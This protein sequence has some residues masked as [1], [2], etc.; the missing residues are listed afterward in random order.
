MAATDRHGIDLA[1]DLVGGEV[2][3]RSCRMLG[4]GGVLVYLLAE[5]FED[6]SA[7]HGVDLRQ[8]IIHDDRSALE[9]VV[10]LAAA[11]AV[12]PQVSRILKL[13]E[14]ARAHELIEAGQNSRGRIVLEIA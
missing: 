3:E 7:A 5:P 9:R 8:A 1:F 14:A 11:G 6:C 4:P 2:H 13:A 12:V 10:A